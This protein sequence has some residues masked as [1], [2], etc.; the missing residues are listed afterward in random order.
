MGYPY[1]LRS[2]QSR[3]SPKV[4]CFPTL[5]DAEL[6]MLTMT[7]I[8]RSKSHVSSLLML[9]Y[10]LA[11]VVF[12]SKKHLA[13]HQI[14]LNARILMYQAIEETSLKFKDWG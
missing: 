2:G 6:N 1:T 9:A 11:C 12:L 10:F 3:D 13:L 8:W 4:F 14:E 7:N 5:A